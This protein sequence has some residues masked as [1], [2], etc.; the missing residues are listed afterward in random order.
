MDHILKRERK[1]STKDFKT[2]A[3]V[4]AIVMEVK[5]E[6]KKVV[7]FVDELGAPQEKGYKKSC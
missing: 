7:L 1:T 6:D 4:E 5:P 3:T 2:G